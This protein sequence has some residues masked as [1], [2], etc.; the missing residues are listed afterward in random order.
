MSDMVILRS[1]K[2]TLARDMDNGK[3]AGG[4]TRGQ[5]QKNYFPQPRAQ[6]LGLRY[7]MAGFFAIACDSRVS[8]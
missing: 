3:G 1:G 5:R 7:F 8:A 2:R 6:I 4:I